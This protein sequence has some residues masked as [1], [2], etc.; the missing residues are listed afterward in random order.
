MTKVEHDHLQQGVPNDFTNFKVLE[1]FLKTEG[2]SFQ[3]IRPGHGTDKANWLLTSATRG[4][5]LVT[6]NGHAIGVVV[7]DNLEATIFD[8]AEKQSK[9]LNKRSL[10]YSIGSKVDDIRL[11]VDRRSKKAKWYNSL[12]TLVENL[13]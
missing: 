4:K 11:I 1:S 3:Q 9:R 10:E 2:I 8:S 6:G 7:E 12:N 5:Y 13:P